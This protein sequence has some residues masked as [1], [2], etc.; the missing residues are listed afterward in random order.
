[1]PHVQVKGLMCMAPYTEDEGII[2]KAFV[3]LR[4]IKDGIVKRFG[5]SAKLE[6][7]I[8][9]FGMSSDYRIA[10][11][12]GSTMIRV[13]SAIFKEASFM[14][15]NGERSLIFVQPHPKLISGIPFQDYLHKHLIGPL[16][17]VD[18]DFQ[19]PLKKAGRLAACYSR[20]PDGKLALYDDAVGS[21]Y[22]AAPVFYSGGGGLVSTAADYLKFTQMLLSGGAAGGTRFLSRKTI[23]LMASNHL[24]GGQDLTQLSRSLFSEAT[25]AGIG[26]GLGFAVNLDPARVLLP[27]SVGEHYWGGAAST[28]FWID[29]AED[30]TVVFMTQ[31]IP[32]STYPIRRE[33]RTLVYSALDD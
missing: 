29:P 14:P 6:M 1:M 18:T 26:F 15:S 23:A 8:M 5:A 16:G 32:S 20:G 4:E 22:L 9:S 30:L 24:P 13:G 2:R 27:G 12:E 19:V 31:L 11:Q 10:L 17:M 28:A 21:A 3:D 33:L 7:K 25:N